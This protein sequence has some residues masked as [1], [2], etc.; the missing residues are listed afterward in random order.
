S[1]VPPNWLHQ[2]RNRRPNQDWDAPKATVPIVERWEDIIIVV[3]GASGLHG[4]F[5]PTFGD[6]SLSVT[7]PIAE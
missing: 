5:L 4:Q 1:D 6:P 3:V 7:K 2:Y